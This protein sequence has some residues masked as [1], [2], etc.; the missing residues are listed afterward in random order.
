VL[1]CSWENFS[2][3]YFNHAVASLM[4]WIQLMS[5]KWGQW[6]YCRVDKPF[7]ALSSSI[8]SSSS[9]S[10][11]IIIIPSIVIIIQ[12]DSE[13]AS[14]QQLYMERQIIVN[15]LK[16]W[17]ESVTKL[18]RSPLHRPWDMIIKPYIKLLFTSSS[19]VKNCSQ[20]TKSM[21]AAY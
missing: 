21:S 5:N 14:V 2:V 16:Q 20:M 3:C 4:V 10:G 13:T 19:G 12:T 15:C 9:S 7:T 1:V 11:I 17:K 8:T 18:K 6:G